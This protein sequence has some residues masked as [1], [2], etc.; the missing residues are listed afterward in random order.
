MAVIGLYVGG[1]IGAGFASGQELVFFFL[2]FG[3][4]GL[5]GIFL[6][7]V[8]LTLGTALILEFSAEQALTSYHG[9]FLAMGLKRAGLFEWAYS[10]ILVVGSAV[11]LAG[12]AA[13]AL[14]SGGSE[15]FRLVTALLLFVVLISGRKGILGVGRWLAPFITIFLILLALRHL[16]HQGMQLTTPGDQSPW[17][18]FEA[19]LLYASYNLGFSIAVLAG[20]AGL[21][22]KTRQ[23]WAVAI[24]A[25]LL[26]GGALLLLFLAL[27]TLSLPQ[28]EAPMP[29]EILAALG[30]R[31]ILS[32]YHFVLWASM[33]TT[34]LANSFALTT[35]LTESGKMN[36]QRASLLVIVLS[37]T[38]SYVGFAP[39]IRIAYPLLGLVVLWSLAYLAWWRWRFYETHHPN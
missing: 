37:V 22:K 26:L 13:L 7:V 24:I 2:R 5:V 4:G 12:C 11:M 30:G 17:G 1:V 28:L 23:R 25:N 32:G 18:G 9:L 16:Q 10:F 36:W 3:Q 6:T 39:L 27:N 8:L 33:Y 34:A 21:L 38:L 31:V 35:R 15:L 20:T 29:L 19:A 14:E